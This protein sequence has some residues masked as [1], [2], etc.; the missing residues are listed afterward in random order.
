MHRVKVFDDTFR[1][2][3]LELKKN[4]RQ[5]V[6]KIGKFKV[7]IVWRAKRS[8]RK[9]VSQVKSRTNKEKNF[10]WKVNGKIPIAIPKVKHVRVTPCQRSSFSSPPNSER[11]LLTYEDSATESKYHYPPSQS[12][13][14]TCPAAFL[15]QSFPPSANMYDA[16]T[17]DTLKCHRGIRDQLFFTGATFSTVYII[18]ITYDILPLTSINCV[19]CSLSTS[20]MRGYGL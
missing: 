2:M 4:N 3:C 16:N 9:V 8:G 13:K 14:M 7:Q 1:S 11:P 15:F 17:N 19:H 20:Y 5:S 18:V 12:L 6:S 10:Q